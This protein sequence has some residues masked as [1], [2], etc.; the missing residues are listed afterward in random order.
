M[1]N[2]RLRRFFVS[3]FALLCLLT[4]FL[5]REDNALSYSRSDFNFRTYEIPAGKGFYTGV[6]CEIRS[7]DHVVS[8]KDAYESGASKWSNEL[9]QKY[10]NDRINHVPACSRI[11]S[12]KGALRPS[13]LV[14]IS[15]DGS[16]V[17]FTFQ[18]LCSYLE[19]YRRVKE[20]Y[21]LTISRNNLELFRK[22]GIPLQANT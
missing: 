2:P 8:L 5:G 15:K 12:A 20:K 21:T 1:N 7:V 14:R 11:N 22:C 17:D 10:A 19:I 4:H 3:L 6:H 9:K 16:G 13:D 18:N